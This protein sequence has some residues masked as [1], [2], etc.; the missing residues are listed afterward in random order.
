MKN[1]INE[2]CSVSVSLFILG[3]G[4][5]QSCLIEECVK[6]NLLKCKKD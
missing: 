3:K 4:Y 5:R 2:T 1:F 6:W